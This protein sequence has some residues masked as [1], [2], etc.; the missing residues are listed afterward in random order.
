MNSARPIDRQTL[1]KKLDELEADD[2]QL[3]K[4]LGTPHL[5][6]MLLVWF[7]LT[8]AIVTT[9]G[10]DAVPIIICLQRRISMETDDH[11]ELQ[12]FSHVLGFLAA[13]T[14]LEVEVKNWMI[15][16]YEVELE[17]KIGSGGLF[18][19]YAN[20][21]FMHIMNLILPCLQRRRTYRHLAGKHGCYQSF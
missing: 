1:H 12:F 20:P 21:S 15:S 8:Q 6:N 7:L 11:R 17:G 18:V 3:A 4:V 19:C 2:D 10:N 5:L 9:I 13:S 16:P 14:G